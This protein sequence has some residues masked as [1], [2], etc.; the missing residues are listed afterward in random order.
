MLILLRFT[1]CTHDLLIMVILVKS[2]VLSDHM[3]PSLSMLEVVCVLAT[4]LS[5][6]APQLFVMNVSNLTMSVQTALHDHTH[7]PI[8]VAPIVEGL[9]S[10]KVRFEIAV[11]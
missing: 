2:P 3:D 4:L 8:V 5:I 9:P 11:L 1:F 7:V 6:V 10:L